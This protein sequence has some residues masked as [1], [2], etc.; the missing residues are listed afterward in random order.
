MSRIR[1]ILSCVFAL[2][3]CIPSAARAWEND[4]DDSWDYSWD[5]PDRFCA[6]DEPA[7]SAVVQQKLAAKFGVE[8]SQIASLRDESLGY[9]EI[10]HTLTL[11]ERQPGGI[12]DENVDNILAMRQDQHMGWGQIAKSEGTTLGAAKREFPVQPV[13]EP[14]P[15]ATTEQAATAQPRSLSRSGT[16]ATG[17]RRGSTSATSHGGKSSAKLGSSSHSARSVASNA[18]P[19]PSAHAY[20]R[21]SAGGSSARAGSNGK[22]KGHK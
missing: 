21:G 6:D 13:V 18:R 16:P 3:L 10:D 2:A 12:T 8:E 14:A 19:A 4:G 1:P 11:A 15:H 7:D 5:D 22:A 20:G 17:T 9:G